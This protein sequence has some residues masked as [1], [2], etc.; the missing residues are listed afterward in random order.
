MEDTNKNKGL[1]KQ[2]INILSEKGINDKNVLNALNNI[3]RQ[4]FMESGLKTYA[5]TDKAYPIGEGQTI[6]QPYTV[7]YQTQLLKTKA[8]DKVLEVG[9]GSGYQTSVLIELGCKVFTIE[10]QRL[11]FKKAELL[12]KKIKWKP[13]KIVFGDGYKGLKINAPYD[14]IIVTAGSP[15]LPNNLMLQLKIGGRLVIPIGTKE[16]TMTRYVRVSDKEYSKETFG[17]F[18]FVPLL[19]DKV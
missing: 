13:K 1:R 2:L 16:Q 5:Y 14:A 9:T 18:R 17:S 7:A 10:R 3:P 8:G 15:E 6:S 12:F 11:L 19:K 4:W